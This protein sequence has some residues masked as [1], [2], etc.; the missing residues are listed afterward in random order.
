MAPSADQPEG[1]IFEVV[2]CDEEHHGEVVG[3][4][5][6]VADVD[7][8]MPE[9]EALR[10]RSI[11]A[12]VRSFEEYVG[13]AYL[14]SRFTLQPIAPSTESWID[15]DRNVACIVV[16]LEAAVDDGGGPGGVHPVSRRS[17]VAGAA[18]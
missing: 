12:C 8:S 11:D 10:T 3:R 2:D 9:P 1:T 13:I 7:D 15:G 4:A 16:V 6:M 5:R 17:S 14:E 18:Q